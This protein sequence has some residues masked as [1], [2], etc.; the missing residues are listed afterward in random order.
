M[1]EDQ[2]LRDWAHIDC[3]DDN[4]TKLVAGGKAAVLKPDLAVGIHQKARKKGE[5][6]SRTGR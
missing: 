5:C 1:K 4:D 6:V 3:H 2:V